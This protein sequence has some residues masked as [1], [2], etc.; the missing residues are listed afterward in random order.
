MRPRERTEAAGAA[1]PP[2]WAP[3]FYEPGDDEALLALLEEAFDPW[4]KRELAVPALDHLRWKLASHPNA[5]KLHIVGEVDGRVVGWQGC[6]LQRVQ[7][8]G[9]ILLAKQGLDYCVHSE[10]RRL[11]IRTRVR[12]LS[13][14]TPRRNFQLSFGLVSGHAA[15]RRLGKR[16]GYQKERFPANGTESLVR[17]GDAGPTRTGDSRHADWTLRSVPEFDERTDGFWEA[18][19]KPYRFIIE[20][21]RAYLNWRYAD[22]RAGAFQITIAEQGAEQGAELLGYVVTT[23]SYGRGYIADVLALPERTDV[24]GALIDHAVAE[25]AAGGSEAIECWTPVHHPY[26]GVLSA[27]G[28]LHRRRIVPLEA[29]PPSDSSEVM[30]FGDDPRAAI[31][32]AIGDTDMV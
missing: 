19:A 8:D 11:G 12:R 31:H 1:L 25:L 16:D 18:A 17:L 20:R 6:W 26:R 32:V 13:M 14:T 27:N 3:R 21:R 10:Y 2:G 5:T 9:R 15:N 23:A 30:T 7:V 22:P 24:A 28:F 29:H 4:P